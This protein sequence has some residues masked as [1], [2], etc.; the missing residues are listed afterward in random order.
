M[1]TFCLHLLCFFISMTFHYLKN[2]LRYLFCSRHWRGYGVHSPFAFDLV[3]N[4]IREELPYY[5]YSLVEKI[6]KLYH[7]SKKSLEV[8]GRTVPVPELAHGEISPACGQLLFRLV[9]KYKPAN[10]VATKMGMGISSMYLAAPNSKLPVVTFCES[11][12]VA[13]F[14][15]GYMKQTGFGNVF[16][17]KGRADDLSTRLADVDALGL[18]YVNDC[19]SGEDLDRRMEVCLRKRGEQSI[20]V[21]DHIYENASMTAAWHRL[22]ALEEVRVTVDLFHIGIVFFDKKLQKEDYNVRYFPKLHL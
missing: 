5:K 7:T 18:L 12:S 1:G 20:F 3:T 13:S 11:E 8:D 16:V 19:F 22:Q 2:Y 17:I 10:V 9:N 21:I 14:V 15:S 4:V 6:R